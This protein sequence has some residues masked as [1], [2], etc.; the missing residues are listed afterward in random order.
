VYNKRRIQERIR[1]QAVLVVLG[2]IGSSL[3][4]GGCNRN[5]TDAVAI[6]ADPLVTTASAKPANTG[7]DIAYDSVRQIENSILIALD[8]DMSSGAAQSGEA[9]RRGVVLAVEKINAQGGLLGRPL[10]LIVRDHRGNPDR[11]VDNILEISQMDDVVAV[12]GG[13]HTPVALRELEAIHEKELIYLVPWAAGT[14]IVDNGYSPNF[15]FRVSVRDEYAGGFLVRSAIDR[16]LTR[17]GLLLE[18]T[19]WGRSNEKAMIVALDSHGLKPSA[20]E[21]FNW[22]ETDLSDHLSRLTEAG[23]QAILFV[24]NPL[25]GSRIVGAMSQVSQE[26]RL[27]II[28]HW[29]I[30]G[31]DFCGL[32]GKSLADVDLSFLQTHSFIAPRHPERAKKLFEAYAAR[33]NDCKSQ[34]DVPSPTGT[35]HAYEIVMMLATAVEHIGTIESKAVHDAMESLDSY[36]GIIRDYNPPFQPGHHDALTTDDFLLARYAED[37]TIE[38]FE[39]PKSGDSKK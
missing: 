33:F 1:I 17:I 37:G 24:G 13:L 7:D 4:Y 35:S 39:D 5:S 22:G 10:E 12:A 16:N 26:K 28:S 18:R 36:H 25:E 32:C 38:P 34:R 2:L 23:S 3:V 15:V 11:G 14:P 20:I 31:G 21:W 19:A 8:T 30:T 27:P 9:I 6:S 29:G